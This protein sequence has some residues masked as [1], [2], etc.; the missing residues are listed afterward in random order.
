MPNGINLK[1]REKYAHKC[2]FF[3]LKDYI[4]IPFYWKGKMNRF[5][6]L[7]NKHNGESGTGIISVGENEIPFFPQ[8][9]HNDSLIGTARYESIKNQIHNIEIRGKEGIDFEA[10][11]GES[12]IILFFRIGR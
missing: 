11:D 4:I 9:Q 10:L 12:S 7:Y 5:Y 1:N 8:W 6:L 2:G 3:E